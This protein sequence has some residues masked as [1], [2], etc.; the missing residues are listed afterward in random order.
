M[1]TSLSKTL[2]AMTVLAGPLAAMTVS[3]GGGVAAASAAPLPA[4]VAVAQSNPNVSNLG[5]D[6]TMTQTN[7]SASLRAQPRVRAPMNQWPTRYR[8]AYDVAAA[9]GWR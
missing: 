3:A 1:G 8:G 5:P 6:L 9:A 4:P 2:A 7:G